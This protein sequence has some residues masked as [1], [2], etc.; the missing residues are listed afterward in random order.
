[1]QQHAQPIRGRPSAAILVVAATLAV[2]VAARVAGAQ[3]KGWFSQFLRDDR[4]IMT[5]GILLGCLPVLVLTL[6]ILWRLGGAARARRREAAQE[7][8]AAIE[9]ALLFPIALCVVLIMIQSMLVA[10]GNLAAHKAAYDAVRA[11]I[12]WVPEKVSYDEPRNM[13]GAP[14]S[15]FKLQKIRA[16]AVAA[17]TPVGADHAVGG[18]GAGA[19]AGIVQD[20]ITRF[21]EQSSLRPPNWIRTRLASQLRYAEEFTEVTLE[22][23]RTGDTYGEHEDLTVRVKH[24]LYLSVPYANRIF[25][26][27]RSGRALPGDLGEYATEIVTSHTLT[28]QGVEDDIDVEIFPRAVGRGGS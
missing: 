24:L 22:P 12:V 26:L 4:T 8:T 1:M 7:G 20:G 13:V 21:Y 5:G 6:A 28:N 11:A 16:A 3:G 9:F 17:V 25:G 2:G 27:A 15:S 23:P 10:A 14:D 18:G 19:S